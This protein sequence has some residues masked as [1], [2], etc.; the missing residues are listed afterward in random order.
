MGKKAVINGTY[1]K[2]DTDKGRAHGCEVDHFVI[3]STHFSCHWTSVLL[4]PLMI[5]LS[6]APCYSRAPPGVPASGVFKC[7]AFPA[8]NETYWPMSNFSRTGTPVIIGN[9]KH[10]WSTL[11]S[12]EQY[13][14]PRCTHHPASKITNIQPFLL[15]PFCHWPPPTTT[16]LLP[17]FTIPLR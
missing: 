10:I 9:F 13:N 1:S 5:I 4:C 8:P 14:K 3:I 16:Q 15:H 11:K 12:K 2:R 17:L 6:R 7:R